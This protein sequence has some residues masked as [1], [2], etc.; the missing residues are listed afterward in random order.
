[1]QLT[2][3]GRRQAEQ[4]GRRLRALVGD[5]DIFM[6]TS[7]YERTRE[8]TRI[9]LATLSR[10]EDEEEEERR[11]RLGRRG[12][13]AG[14]A[15]A[16]VDE[17]DEE[18]EGAE[19]DNDQ[20]QGETGLTD[21]HGPTAGR[22]FSRRDSDPED[23]DADSSFSRRTSKEE[24]DEAPALPLSGTRLPWSVLQV[25]EDPRLREREFSGTF[26][27]EQVDRSDEFNYSRFFWRPERGE[28]CADVHDRISLFMGSLWRD[29]SNKPLMQDATVVIVSH[30]LTSR[31]FVMRWLKWRHEMLSRTCNPPNCGLLVLEREDVQT[32]HG[33]KFYYNLTPESQAVLGI[34]SS[35]RALDR[36]NSIVDATSASPGDRRPSL[37]IPSPPR[38]YTS[39][40]DDP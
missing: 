15:L 4:A 13:N 5:S 7:P 29:I 33:P 30:G 32:C 8:T 28:S 35:P 38:P 39:S 14:A 9:I 16:R 18:G 17:E 40:Q 34:D 19:K 3:A 31:L 1:M 10:I 27:R 11:R 21:G 37:I 24:P 20:A 2:D 26:Q 23:H 36:F 25:R 6:Y 22:L 12:G